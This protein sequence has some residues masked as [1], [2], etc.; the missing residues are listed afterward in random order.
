MFYHL[1]IKPALQQ[2]SLLQVSKSCCREETEILLLQQSLHLLGVL[3]AYHAGVFRG[4]RISYL[5][6]WEETR[7]PLKTPAW[8]ASVL[9]TQGKLVL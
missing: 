6:G 5:V 7:A 3:L 4:A 1:R 9:P 2:I 8:E